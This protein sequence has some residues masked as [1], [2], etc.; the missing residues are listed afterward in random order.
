MDDDTLFQ[1]TCGGTCAVSLT[2]SLACNR[3]C[4]NGSTIL[5]DGCKCP[6]GL[7]G[8]CCENGIIITLTSE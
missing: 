6:A 7:E 5:A 4:P 1:A 2:E 3:V 8:K